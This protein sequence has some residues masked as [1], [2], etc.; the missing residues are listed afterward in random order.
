LRL[1]SA[2]AP[3][4]IGL[5]AM[6]SV[7]RLTR[8]RAGLLVGVAAIT[9]MMFFSK[10]KLA[11]FDSVLACG[12]GIAVVA[13]CYNLVRGRR[14]GALSVWLLCYLA[15]AAGVL[16]KGP[17]ALMAFGPGLLAAALVT[18][19]LHELLSWRHLAGAAIFT[20]LVGGYLW[21]LWDAAGAIAFEQPLAEAR[22]RGF[23]WTLASFARTLAKPLIIMVGFLPWSL[24]WPWS[25]VTENRRDGEAESATHDN[26]NRASLA[27]LAAGMLVFMAVPTYEPRYFLPLSVPS[28]IVAVLALERAAGASRLARRLASALATLCAITLAAAGFVFRLP[29]PTRI[30]I[31]AIGVAAL[32]ATWALVPRSPRQRVVRALP[33]PVV[34]LYN[35]ARHIRFRLAKG[36]GH[37]SLRVRWHLD[38]GRGHRV[39]APRRHRA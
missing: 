26:L 7:G 1:P 35:S 34:P 17:P 28:A 8:P 39:S 9:N 10:T 16:T 23:D 6:L 22:Q 19:R 4:V 13:A 20:L 27:F 5:V 31:A 33:G 24:A 2:L 38:P 37:G 36:D 30:S 15:L 14:P 25:L 3:I 12:V 18:G 32:L 21:L 11:E 29:T